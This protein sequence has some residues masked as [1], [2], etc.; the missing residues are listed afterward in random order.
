M[1][2]EESTD[3]ASAFRSPVL[4]ET[5]EKFAL[6]LEKRMVSGH[7]DTDNRQWAIVEMGVPVESFERI[8]AL[9]LRTWKLEKSTLEAVDAERDR[10]RAGYWEIYRRAMEKE[11]LGDALR[12]LDAVARLEGLDQPTRVEIGLNQ[13]GITNAARETISSLIARMQELKSGKAVRSL[14]A[15]QEENHRAMNGHANGHHRTIIDV[16]TGD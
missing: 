7:S 15:I 5:A 4:S 10:V 8:R 13:G 2:D 12:A 3:L 11:K 6:L 16:E 14:K 1:S 9:I